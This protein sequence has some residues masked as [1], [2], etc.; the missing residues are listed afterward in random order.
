MTLY[1]LIVLRDFLPVRLFHI[2]CY[3]LGFIHPILHVFYL[4]IKIMINMF[5]LKFFKH[6]NDSG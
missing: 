5:E 6:I 4:E 1:S 3:C 2:A